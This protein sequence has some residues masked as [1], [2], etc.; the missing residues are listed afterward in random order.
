MRHL[1]C[2]YII[3]YTAL[4]ALKRRVYPS[5]LPSFWKGKLIVCSV[6]YVVGEN[7]VIIVLIHYYLI[8]KDNIHLTNH[9]TL[10]LRYIGKHHPVFCTYFVLYF[11]YQVPKVDWCSRLN[12]PR[13]VIWLYLIVVNGVH[14]TPK[15]SFLITRKTTNN[16]WIS[17][18]TF[19]LCYVSNNRV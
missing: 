6:I 7:T 14:N 19:P 11:V 13:R 4:K 16:L 3:S 17:S 12:K 1:K 2:K 5:F 15:L 18:H 10:R 8:F 9:S